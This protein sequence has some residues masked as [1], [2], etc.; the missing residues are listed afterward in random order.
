[1]GL[2]REILEK[3]EVPQDWVKRR[4]AKGR[5]RE[6]QIHSTYEHTDQGV[7]V[8]TSHQDNKMDRGEQGHRRG[9]KRVRE[10]QKRLRK[11]FRYYRSHRNQQK[12][13]VDIEKDYDTVDR[14]KIMTSLKHTGIGSIVA[15][16][17]RKSYEGV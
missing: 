11:C 14:S 16:V 8:D 7:W 15:Y 10:E 13:R 1:M 6:L 2:F 3:G 9:A 4:K 12:L 5:N 17:I